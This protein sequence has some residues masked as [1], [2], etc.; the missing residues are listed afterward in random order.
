[1]PHICST[2]VYLHAMQWLILLFLCAVWN[3]TTLTGPTLIYHDEL[4]LDGT[5][6]PP[7][8]I[9]DVNRPGALVCRSETQPRVGWRNSGNGFF[10]DTISRTGT[11]QQI[12]NDAAAVPNLS[13]LSC[14]TTDVETNPA[15]NG[16]F[17]CW[18]NVLSGDP[19]SALDN[20]VY[21]GI[22][23]RG[24]G[25]TWS[26]II[27]HVYPHHKQQEFQEMRYLSIL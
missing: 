25:E 1:M 12:R 20:S 10:F 2:M 16:L 19:D 23:A 18:V 11:I 3:G 7:L 14:G 6:P 26:I 21:V 22:Y 15:F 17:I 27:M 5:N 8:L 13:K 24:G 4:I 9:G